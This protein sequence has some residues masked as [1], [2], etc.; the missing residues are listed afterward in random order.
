[1]KDWRA[2]GFLPFVAVC[3]SKTRRS[4]VT[5]V[6]DSRVLTVKLMLWRRE[7]EEP[8]RGAASDALLQEVA[9]PFIVSAERCS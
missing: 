5:S 9:L 8:E 1:M 2:S 3:K 4:F 7:C 6:D